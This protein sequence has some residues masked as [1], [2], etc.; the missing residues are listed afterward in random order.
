MKL[1]TGLFIQRVKV[2]SK[3]SAK[4]KLFKASP[5]FLLSDTSLQEKC[6]NQNAFLDAIFN[7]EKRHAFGV[8]V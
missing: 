5:L 4:E 7:Q 8:K 2:Y 3:I 1:R 6:C